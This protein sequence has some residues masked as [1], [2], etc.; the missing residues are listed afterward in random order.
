[1]GIIIPID[2]IIFFR[3]IQTT[4]QSSNM[5]TKQKHRYLGRSPSLG[6]DR[7]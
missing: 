1:M 3:G 5:E 2:Y 6:D 4:N 7:E